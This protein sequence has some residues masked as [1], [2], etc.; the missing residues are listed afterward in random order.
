MIL[1][2]LLPDSLTR[3]E[4][5]SPLTRKLQFLE[6]VIDDLENGRSLHESYQRHSYPDLAASHIGKFFHLAFHQGIALLPVLYELTRETKF[7]IEREREIA[8]EIA[9]AKATLTLLTFFPTIILVGAWLAKIIHLDRTLLSPI[10]IAMFCIS[11]LLQILGRG[12]SGQIIKS[13]RE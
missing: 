11:I 2:W 10:P 4:I 1:T 7:Q 13:V 3:P 5:K 9:P 6:S 8:I 12:W